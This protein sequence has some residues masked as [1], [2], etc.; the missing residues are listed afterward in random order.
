M[1]DGN[2]TMGKSRHTQ[3][4]PVCI[5]GDID[6]IEVCNFREWLVGFRMDRKLWQL[7]PLLGGS[8][9]ALGQAYKDDGKL[10]RSL[11]VVD[12]ACLGLCLHV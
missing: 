11:K 12:L 4:I 10:N 3:Q 2:K 5:C 9:L 6:C 7:V 8:Y 1:E